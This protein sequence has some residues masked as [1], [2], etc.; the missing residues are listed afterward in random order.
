M[1]IT[2]IPSKTTVLGVDAVDGSVVI[3][4]T[5]VVTYKCNGSTE[6]EHCKKVQIMPKYNSKQSTY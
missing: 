6:K 4:G 5:V 1:K 3:D 2:K